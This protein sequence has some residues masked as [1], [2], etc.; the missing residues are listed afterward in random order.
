MNTRQIAVAAAFALLGSSAF[1]G[2]EFDPMTGFN[3][4][5]APAKTAKVAAPVKAAAPVSA[6]S[7]VTREQVRAEF[8]RSRNDL[9]DDAPS[10]EHG[11]DYAKAPAGATRDREDVRAEAR[12]SV[13][14][15][16]TGS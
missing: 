1:A 11:N 10:Y 3:L 5:P 7:S 4:D 9:S 8:L 14:G 2:G 15:S 16:K 13:R 12:A 6:T